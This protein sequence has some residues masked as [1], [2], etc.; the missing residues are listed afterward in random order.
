MAEKLSFD[1]FAG[2]N[3][4]G[5]SPKITFKTM[6]QTIKV[7]GMKCQ[8]CE[9]KVET[10]LGKIDGVAVV[11]A[12]HENNKVDVDYEPT[13]VSAAELAETIEDCGFE[14]TL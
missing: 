1:T 14:A 9:A 13:R 12:D 8:H 3:N 6:K 11:K 4:D 10:A 2:E 5:V 7:T